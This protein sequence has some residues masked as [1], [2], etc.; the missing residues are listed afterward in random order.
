MT[1][2][3]IS[4]LNKE[5]AAEQRLSNENLQQHL[6][7]QCDRLESILERLENEEEAREIPSERLTMSTTGIQIRESQIPED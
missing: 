2:H 7:R 3:D 5:T 6:S 4:I 1:L